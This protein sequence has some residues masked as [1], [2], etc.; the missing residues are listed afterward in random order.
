MANSKQAIKRARQNDARRE[1]LASQRSALRTS[2]KKIQKLGE[3]S[4][5]KNAVKSQFSAT[6]SQ[7]DR[8]AKNIIHPNKASRIKKR[9]NQSL[10]KAALQ[11][12]TATKVPT[13]KKRSKSSKS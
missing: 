7:I 6:Q 2:I 5:D 1:H 9:L 8:A 13:K 11:P 12:A 4:Q 3:E 10:K